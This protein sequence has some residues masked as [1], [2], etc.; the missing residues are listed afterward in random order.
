MQNLPKKYAFKLLREQASDIDAFESQTHENIAI[1]LFEIIQ[2]EEKAVTIGLEGPWGAGKSTVVAILREKL[3]KANDVFFF[4]F[5]AW[6]HEGDPLRRVFL[7]SLANEIGQKKS[8]ESK[9]NEQIEAITAAITGR[10]KTIKTWIRQNTTILGRWFGFAVTLIPLG[11]VLLSKVNYE[12][13]IAPWESGYPDPQLAIGVILAAAPA[14][15]LF[16]NLIRICFKSKQ[17]RVD[18]WRFLQSDSLQRTTQD[19]NEDRDQTSVEFER[20]FEKI[21]MIAH[22]EFALKKLVLVVDNLDR[23]DAEEAFR[24]WAVLQTFL[25]QRNLANAK[26]WFDTVWVIVPYDHEG[27]SKLWDKDNAPNRS[28]AKSFFDKSFQLRLDV[29]RSIFKD[30]EGFAKR[31]ME[32]AMLG[33]APEDREKIFHILRIAR[34][35]LNDIPTPREIKNFINQVAILAHQR[36]GSISLDSIA[37]FVNWREILNVD[38]AT[39]RNCLLKFDFALP[40]HAQFLDAKKI[41]PE[42]AALCFGVSLSEAQ[43][44]LLSPLIINAL[45]AGD[46]ATLAHLAAEHGS[47]FWIA[48]EKLNLQPSQ[49]LALTAAKAIFL[50]LWQQYQSRCLFFVNQIDHLPDSR[51]AESFEQSIQNYEFWIHIAHRPVIVFEYLALQIDRNLRQSMISW[52]HR[53]GE[54]NA[55]CAAVRARVPDIQPREISSLDLDKFAE[56]ARDCA[57]HEHTVALIRPPQTILDQF[58]KALESNENQLKDLHFVLRY[59]HR[60]CQS[61]PWAELLAVCE[62]VALNPSGNTQGQVFLIILEVSICSPDLTSRISALFANQKFYAALRNPPHSITAFVWSLFSPPEFPSFPGQNPAVSRPAHQGVNRLKSFWIQE[63]EKTASEILLGYKSYNRWS[64]FWRMTKRA[65][66]RLVR[67]MLLKVTADDMLKSAIKDA[68]IREIFEDMQF[69]DEEIMQPLVKGFC[70]FGNLELKLLEFE[71][72]KVSF[73][74]DVLNILRELD[75]SERLR[76]HIDA[77]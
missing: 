74:I 77:S 2:S 15:V 73:L 42:I 21:V 54:L 32:I 56:F 29:P 19:I 44:F 30:W 58:R 72:I 7:E 76:S 67:T 53:A 4:Q 55:I 12:D 3:S 35:S 31:Q 38:A 75:I 18:E 26:S 39:I 10:T 63:N 6:A 37:Y 40:E 41:I 50:G 33:W 20:F 14:I 68:S 43:R 22:S 60:A 71:N 13:L 8:I 17:K 64:D 62:G 23:I 11:G 49:S 47:S 25:Q 52:V 69:R 9:K 66:W 65:E 36:Q 34:S 70:D 24:I 51:Y 59:L 61:I 5:D 16:I 45:N 57:N 1:T 48:F 27:L 28:I 46:E